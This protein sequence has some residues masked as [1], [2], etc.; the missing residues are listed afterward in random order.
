MAET[1]WWR[2][3]DWRMA[4]HEA[5]PD[6]VLDLAV[7]PGV[8]LKSASVSMETSPGRTDALTWP[9]ERRSLVSS[10]LHGE[11]AS[12]RRSVDQ[13]SKGPGKFLVAP[14]RRQPGVAAA[15]AALQVSPL[16]STPSTSSPTLS[17]VQLLCASK[18][19]GSDLS[20]TSKSFEDKTRARDSFT[21]AVRLTK[22]VHSDD[23]P[24]AMYEPTRVDADA[25]SSV[26]DSDTAS[27][28]DDDGRTEN[29]AS[30]SAL[31]VPVQT[32]ASLPA[33]AG[34][35]LLGRF[36]NGPQ[37]PPR[38]QSEPQRQ[39][40]RVA[41]S[42]SGTGIAIN[43]PRR[44]SF[45]S[46]AN[47]TFTFEPGSPPNRRESLAVSPPTRSPEALVSSG[48]AS[49][50]APS[51]GTSTTTSTTVAGQGASVHVPSATAAAAAAA[52][53][54]STRSMSFAFGVGPSLLRKSDSDVASLLPLPLPSSLESSELRALFETVSGV[55]AALEDM[56]VCARTSAC[57]PC[58]WF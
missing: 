6:S 43:S 51:R 46:D 5:G 54:R 10:A 24:A 34:D 16:I 19:K 35:Q 3:H 31:P 50:S 27:G 55:T 20:Y 12:Q 41:D 4:L 13:R 23:S 18:L 36:G 9:S 45:A 33:P 11:S 32:A 38:L 14:A 2:R 47:T 52:A 42:R 39:Q 7:A 29:H 56:K 40:T 8:Q 49:V 22:Q 21:Q 30:T 28:S 57:T 48:P 17:R 1:E 25:W 53:A 26:S 15:A 44:L 58:C 37:L